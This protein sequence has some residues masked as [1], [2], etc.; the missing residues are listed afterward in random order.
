M[1]SRL[2]RCFYLSF[3]KTWKVLRKADARGSAVDY[4][5]RWIRW[6]SGGHWVYTCNCIPLYT[7]LTLL[8]PSALCVTGQ[9]TVYGKVAHLV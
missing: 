1:T 8:I 2:W 7:S 5:G 4:R 3:V 9:D 6:I